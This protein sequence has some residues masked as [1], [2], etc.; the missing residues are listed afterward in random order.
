MTGDT[1][2]PSS[3]PARFPHRSKFTVHPRY[4]MVNP[5]PVPVMLGWIF[6]RFIMGPIPGLEYVRGNP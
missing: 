6:R 4:F 2:P 1:G 3:K 5:R